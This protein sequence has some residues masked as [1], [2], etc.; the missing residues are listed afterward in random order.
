[1][2]KHEILTASV[3]DV[4]KLNN[5]INSAYRG[6][7]AKKGWTNEIGIIE[8]ARINEIEVRRMIESPN[9]ILLKFVNEGNTIIGCC[10][11]EI[12]G[13]ELYLGTLTVSPDIQG[14]GIGKMMLK[15]AD[16]YAKAHNYTAIIITVVSGRVELIDWYIRHG[17]QLTGKSKPFPA[18][19]GFGNPLKEIELIELKRDFNY[20]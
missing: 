15:Y 18:Q 19:M 8:G 17:Y 11:L 13:N 6:E 20:N 10:Y 7:Y 9:G 12:H 1:M 14:Q 16:E 2:N 3:E 4:S 5:L